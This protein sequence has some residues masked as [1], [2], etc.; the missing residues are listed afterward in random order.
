MTD[1]NKKASA[2][3]L[4][5]LLGLFILLFLPA[6]TFYYWQAWIFLATFSLPILAITLYLAKYDPKLLARRVNA[7]A[8]AEKEKTQK[9]IQAIAAML[10]I[11]VMAF[12]AIDHRIHWSAVPLRTVFAGN[13]LVLL[14]LL[15][16]FFVFKKNTF[17]SATIE[18]DNGQKVISTGPY[19]LVR[20]PMYVGGIILFF[21]TPL[22]L[23]SSW[24]LLTVVPLALVIVWRL[25]DEENF[26]LKNLPGYA[27]YRSKVKYRLVPFIW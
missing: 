6:W 7:G 2:G 9:L 12:P 13:G 5:L 27:E 15:I 21:G 16:I 8:G 24:G 10:F 14:G 1:L 20:H 4:E 17:A 22:A 3:F 23:G 25:L 18:A 11:I 19:A 26:L